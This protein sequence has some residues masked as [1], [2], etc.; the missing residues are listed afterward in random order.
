MNLI[1]VIPT[2]N[3]AS[4]IEAIVT[5]VLAVDP[6]YHVLVVD[7]CSPDETAAIVTRLA[8]RDGRIHLLLRQHDRGLGTAVRDGF[9]EALRLGAAFVGQMDADGSHDP[10]MF[11]AMLGKLQRGEADVVVGSRYV[12]DGQI[13]GWGLYRYANSHV[14]N[15]LAR[16][17]TGVPLCDATTGLRLFRREVIE[18]LNLDALLSQGYSI[19][20]ETNSRAHRLG[21]RLAEVPITFHQRTAGVSK[22]GLREIVRFCV[23]LVRSRFHRIPSAARRRARAA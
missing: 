14:A 6:G 4:N 16:L 5:R 22:M 19:I 20:L 1:V 3:E 13:E 11:P 23:F 17:M 18:A 9:R 8:D 2:Y 21:F 12:R 15:A 7:D 10:A